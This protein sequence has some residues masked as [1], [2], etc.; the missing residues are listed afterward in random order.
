VFREVMNKA[1]N[2]NREQGLL[3]ATFQQKAL[4]TWALPM[5]HSANAIERSVWTLDLTGAAAP[6]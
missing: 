4:L 2:A 5:Y 6:S 3:A 1:I